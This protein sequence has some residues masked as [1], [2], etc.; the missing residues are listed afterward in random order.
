MKLNVFNAKSIACATFVSELMLHL[1]EEVQELA[2]CECDIRMGSD[3]S[4]GGEGLNCDETEMIWPHDF[5]ILDD[6]QIF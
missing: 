4:L 3:T 1:C 2:D 5:H 6:P